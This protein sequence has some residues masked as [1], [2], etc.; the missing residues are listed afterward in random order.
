MQPVPVNFIPDTRPAV[1]YLWDD[2]G[3]PQAVANPRLSGDTVHGTVLGG[4]QPVAVPLS[5]VQRVS[6]IRVNRSRTVFL[7]G[8]LTVM[9][10]LV[11]YAVI[12]QVSGDDSGFCDYDVQP[13]G[14]GASECGYPSNP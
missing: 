11:T 3:V 12:A 1:V 2:N 8:G 9:S 5:E 7:I 6:T 13:M 4:S 10:A 14:G